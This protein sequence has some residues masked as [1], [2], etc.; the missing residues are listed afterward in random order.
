MANYLL[1]VPIID[2][3]ILR[4]SND[5]VTVTFENIR[6]WSPVDPR[7]RTIHRNK[8]EDNTV[9]SNSGIDASVEMT[10][11]V[12]CP[13]EQ[14]S[15]LILMYDETHGTGDGMGTLD[16][17]LPDGACW[18]FNNSALKKSP[19]YRAVDNTAGAELSYT[20]I[21]DCPVGEYN[22]S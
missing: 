11:T 22:D 17:V 5:D 12:P 18:T 10:F 20:L 21:F 4:F 2:Q 13:S 7:D 6:T 16:L 8:L 3:C 15:D 1:G 14:I 9:I 19:L